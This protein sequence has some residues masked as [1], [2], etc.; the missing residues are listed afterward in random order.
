M[1]HTHTVCVCV[2]NSYMCRGVPN[3]VHVPCASKTHSCVTPADQ[4]L[5]LLLQRGESLRGQIRV[6]K[7]P[8]KVFS[9]LRV[10]SA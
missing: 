3:A 4:Q 9:D 5:R 7:E 10:F 8:L 2:K 1:K 6:L